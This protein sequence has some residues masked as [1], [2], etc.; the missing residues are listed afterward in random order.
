MKMMKRREFICQG[1][2]A[3][4]VTLIAKKAGAEQRWS[5]TVYKNRK[6]LYSD[7]LKPARLDDSLE[8]FWRHSQVR[9]GSSRLVEHHCQFPRKGVPI[10]NPKQAI[11][12]DHGPNGFH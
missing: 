9:F 12:S 5:M 2:A 4:A 3:I 8:R 7:G 11:R 6:F 1:M 10:D